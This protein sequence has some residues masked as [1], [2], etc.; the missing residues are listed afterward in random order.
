MPSTV[1][2]RAARLDVLADPERVVEQE[3]DAGDDV[4][5]Q[6]LRA[7]AECYA[8]HAGAGE[9][10]AD[11]DTDRRERD[12]HPDHDQDR[13]DEF[14][15]QGL[16]R[17]R[18][19]VP[20]GARCGGV[21]DEA[22][23]EHG[24]GQLPGDVGDERRDQDVEEGLREHGGTRRAEQAQHVDAPEGRQ[25][26]QGDARQD[27]AEGAPDDGGGALACRKAGFVGAEDLREPAAEGLV[28]QRQGGREQHA[29]DRRPDAGGAAGDDARCPERPDDDEVKDHEEV[30]GA[31]EAHA[32]S[33]AAAGPRRAARAAT[34]GRPARIMAMSSAAISVPIASARIRCASSCMPERISSAADSHADAADGGE[35][36][37]PAMEKAGGGIRRA[38]AAVRPG[39]SG[40]SRKR[41]A[42]A[43]AS[44]T[45]AAVT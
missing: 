40:A 28:E 4:A 8:N 33:D 32:R 6:R 22:A 25:Q 44:A 13:E 41:A 36:H 5:H 45:S 2:L 16:E 39:A 38:A 11:V 14:A 17:A 42:K 35:R 7:E 21:G 10:R 18:P 9:Q 12:H 1:P 30:P 23:I 27:D 15:Q 26:H 37:E 29:R 24:L 31:R 34:K 43:A 19:G 3:E 20:G